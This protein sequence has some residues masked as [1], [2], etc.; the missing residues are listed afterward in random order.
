M[1]LED[2]VAR[3]QR[4][5]LRPA[6]RVL[7]GIVRAIVGTPSDDVLKVAALVVVLRE[8]RF[9]R[10]TLSARIRRSSVAHSGAGIGWRYRPSSLR[11]Q[12][13]ERQ[14]KEERKQRHPRKQTHLTQPTVA[15][16]TS[17]RRSR[18]VNNGSAIA[19]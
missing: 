16:A 8:E 10:G 1:Q 9:R 13:G 3:P 6:G 19:R 2:L 7:E 11:H 17:V 4:M 12:E 5:Q 18:R 14:K 15:P